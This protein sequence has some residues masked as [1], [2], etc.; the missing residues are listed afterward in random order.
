MRAA[1]QRTYGPPDVV[2]I[3]EVTTPVPT[4]NQL[5]VK[6][7]VTTVNRTDGHIRSGKPF[8]MRFLYGFWK[9]KVT[10]LGNEF[11]G[12]VVALG[13]GVQRAKVGDR[14][15]GYCEGPFGAHAEYLVVAEDG[16]IAAIP[17]GLSYEEAAPGTEGSHYA[18]SHLA[19]AKVQPGHSVLVYGATGGIGSAAVQ[20]LKTMGATVTA[21][22]ATCHVELVKGLGAD[23]VVDYLT[24]DFT[25]D[26]RRYDVVFDA[27]G[28]LSFFRCRSLLTPRGVFTSTGPGPC[29]INAILPLATSRSRGRKVVFSMPT[30]DRSTVEYLAG[31]MASGEFRPVIDRRYPLDEIADAYGYVEAGQKIGNVVITVD[32]T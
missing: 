17:Q 12:E 24:Q 15:F 10:V 21:V 16:R 11:A 22:C 27:W 25:I 20:L 14:V 18:M 8:I 6:V 28:H 3:T 2:R 4:R 7:H 29:W 23:K 1:V 13:D 5:L 31:L 32:P 9:P 26:D 19:K 30:I